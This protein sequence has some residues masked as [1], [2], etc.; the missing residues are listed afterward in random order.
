[1]D[2]GPGMFV[3]EPPLVRYQ[4]RPRW[5]P[6]EIN[7]RYRKGLSIFHP[8]FLQLS[9]CRFVLTLYGTGI[10]WNQETGRI[11]AVAFFPFHT[12]IPLSMSFTGSSGKVYTRP[13][14]PPLFYIVAERV[15][16]FWTS[17]IVPTKAR[18]ITQLPI[19]INP[20]KDSQLFFQQGRR[21]PGFGTPSTSCVQNLLREYSVQC[22]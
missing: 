15:R 14:P 8:Q 19:P 9:H 18:C 12:S 4:W 5:T 13:L 7:L 3:E 20:S 17:G 1:M 21:G 11:F 10:V 16:P 22:S 2:L 6:M